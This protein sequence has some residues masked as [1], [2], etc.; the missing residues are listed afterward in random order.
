MCV[1]VDVFR[2]KRQLILIY[3]FFFAGKRGMDAADDDENE[4]LLSN[5]NNS[6]GF[7]QNQRQLMQF[8][9]SSYN[10]QR[11]QDAMA[12]ERQLTEIGQMMTKLA[13]MVH[14]QR[15]TII[16]I[17]SNIDDSREHMEGA[18]SELQKYLATLTG[19]RW[20]MIKVFAILI[21]FALFFALFIA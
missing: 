17:N 5:E 19:N 2:K 16:T 20:L 21:F 11:A 13:T 9:E 7:S 12:V 1:L 10:E 18:I 6:G 14:E 4:Q 15:E 8:E 3:C